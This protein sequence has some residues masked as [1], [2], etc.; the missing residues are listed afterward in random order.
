MSTSAVYSTV[1]DIRLLSFLSYTVTVNE[2]FIL[3]L[4]F[5]Q[6]RLKPT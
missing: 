6:P 3:A 4:E 1:S 5:T 2:S